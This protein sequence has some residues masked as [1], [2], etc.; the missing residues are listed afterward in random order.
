[1]LE[2][3]TEQYRHY[4]RERIKEHLAT[5][6]DNSA[7]SKHDVDSSSTPTAIPHPP[8]ENVAYSIILGPHTGSDN[9]NFANPHLK[10]NVEEV[11]YNDGFI[12]IV[13]VE[14]E[15]RVIKASLY[16]LPEQY[17]KASPIKLKSDAEKKAQNLLSSLSQVIVHTAEVDTLEALSLAVRSFASAPSNYRRIILII[18]T[19]LSTIG[20][21]NFRQGLLEISPVIIAEELAKKQAIPNLKKFDCSLAVTR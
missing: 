2:H 11:M 10:N 6:P 3:K 9:L 21:L 8:N 17:W 16:E 15:P 19:G 20:K 14:G 5:A 4:V 13:S 12:S 18:D 1:M 7:L